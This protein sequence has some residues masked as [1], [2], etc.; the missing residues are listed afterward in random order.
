MDRQNYQLQWSSK[1]LGSETIIDIGNI[2]GDGSTIIAA[3]VSLERASEMVL[4]L[5]SAFWEH[6][7]SNS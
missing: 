2:K 1:D 4:I 3:G 7:S 6:I 5:V